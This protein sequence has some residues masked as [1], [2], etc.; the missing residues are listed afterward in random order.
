MAGI[1][2]EDAE[3]VRIRIAWFNGKSEQLLCELRLAG[4][5][6]LATAGAGSGR[7]SEENTMGDG[8]ATSTPRM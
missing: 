2:T 6:E 4:M 8:S 3:A 5:L 7:G 1:I